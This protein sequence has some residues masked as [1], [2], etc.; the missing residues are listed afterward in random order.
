[1]SHAVPG[2]LTTGA[3]A[4]GHVPLTS[5]VLHQLELEL[6]TQRDKPLD[7]GCLGSRP[8]FRAVKSA[9]EFSVG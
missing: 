9:V 1:M 5:A 2:G 4:A 7:S 3:F 6:P 8:G